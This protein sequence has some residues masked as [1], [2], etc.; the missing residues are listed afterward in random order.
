V[1]DYE[2]GWSDDAG[3]VARAVAQTCGA[4][5]REANGRASHGTQF[6]VADITVPM[7]HDRNGAV[8]ACLRDPATAPTLFV[9]S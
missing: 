3:Y 4:R 5:T 1:T 6:A 9:A 8:L 2:R 7:S